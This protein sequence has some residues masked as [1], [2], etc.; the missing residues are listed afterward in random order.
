MYKIWIVLSLVAGMAG[1]TLAHAQGASKKTVTGS[2]SVSK[3]VT[4]AKN[5]S[6]FSPKSDL[7]VD[8]EEKAIEFYQSDVKFRLTFAIKATDI[9]SVKDD[10]VTFLSQVAD[11]SRYRLLSRDS[12]DYSAFNARYSRYDRSSPKGAYWFRPVSNEVFTSVVDGTTFLNSR[13]RGRFHGQVDDF[14]FS[15]TPD[16]ALATWRDGLAIFGVTIDLCYLGKFG[17][18]GATDSTRVLKDGGLR[19]AFIFDD[20]L[21]YE[22]I[23][24]AP[25]QKE[26]FQMISE[27]FKKSQFSGTLMA[28]SLV[29]RGSLIKYFSQQG[30]VSTVSR[31]QLNYQ[32]FLSQTR[33]GPGQKVVYDYIPVVAT[34]TPGIAIEKRDEG[35]Q[36]AVPKLMA[37]VKGNLARFNPHPIKA[38][39]FADPIRFRQRVLQNGQ[40]TTQFDFY[41]A[42][43]AASDPEVKDDFRN[44]I[45][46]GL[47]AAGL[48]VL[49]QEEVNAYAKDRP[50][51]R[52]DGILAVP[53]D[54]GVFDHF[55]GEQV[56]YNDRERGR[57]TG[58]VDQLVF[59]VDPGRADWGKGY[60]RR[61]M[62][63]NIFELGMAQTG[64]GRPSEPRGDNVRLQV[65]VL[66]K[67][68][69]NLRTS[70]RA[71]CFSMN[72]Q[73]LFMLE[74]S[75]LQAVVSMIREECGRL[76]RMA[77]K[78]LQ[79]GDVENFSIPSWWKGEGKTVS[80]PE[81]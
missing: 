16:L 50:F 20:G 14:Y 27:A 42:I 33:Q 30:A 1:S 73:V 23:N 48:R 60:A 79:K 80:C 44:M 64:A 9:P 19:N 15:L 31:D 41:V 65:E 37:Q 17:F 28:G 59:Q 46:K 72:G 38:E 67:M 40:G 76:N 32:A 45:E 58:Y 35:G 24:S 10:F 11:P 39:I 77:G 49:R 36:L 22:R 70:D 34:D 54:Q 61:K 5:L 25:V 12:A 81:N 29:T 8:D 13:T 53:K 21:I 74:A 69:A 3:E 43:Q 7:K 56:F 4:I 57:N 26:I 47:E 18:E 2:A 62:S 71:V 52:K 75:N 6:A 68:L 55:A 63:I 51:S 66:E 78:V